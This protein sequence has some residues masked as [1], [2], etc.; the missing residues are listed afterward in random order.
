MTTN[1]YDLSSIG[2]RL[3]YFQENILKVSANQFAK[4]AGM[5]YVTLRNLYTGEIKPRKGTIQK[6]LQAFAG[7]INPSWIQTGKGKPTLSA[8]QE[9]PSYQL[10]TS[11]QHWPSVGKKLKNL[12]RSADKS[13]EAIAQATGYSLYRL[14]KTL[15]GKE[16]PTPLFMSIILSEVGL[17]VHELAQEVGIPLAQPATKVPLAVKEE[18]STVAPQ[19]TAGTRIHQRAQ[20]ENRQQEQ[21]AALS[22]LQ[23]PATTLVPATRSEGSIGF[24][25][26]RLELDSLTNRINHLEERLS[27]LG[28]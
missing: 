14:N 5:A 12:M 8:T 22:G 25:E 18:A 19:T 20:P 2:G 3:H 28:R 1:V 17:T 6:I 15:R 24:R 10:M 4:E 26:M 21:Q 13:L 9:N 23:A 16:F 11:G 27:R 7:F